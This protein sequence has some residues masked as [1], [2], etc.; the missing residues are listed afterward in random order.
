MTQVH[1]IIKN[2]KNNIKCELEDTKMHEAVKTLND[3]HPKE[4]RLS[5]QKKDLSQMKKKQ[6][7]IIAK[8]LENIFFLQTQHQSK[9][10]Y[11]HLML[12]PFTSSEIRK[13]VWT[14]KN[15]KSSRMDQI[16]V[17]LIEYSPGVV[18]QK[19]KE[20]THMKSRTKF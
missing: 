1:N 3:W 19:G 16:S 15:N 13:T 14:L 6:P 11:Q 7:E 4:N 10:Y 17:E 2:E 8:Y 18:Y 9:T 5:K 20:S 12:T